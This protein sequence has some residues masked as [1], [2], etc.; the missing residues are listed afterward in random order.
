MGF[1]TP[2]M[3]IYIPAAGETNYD[4]SFAAGMINI[5][6]HDHSGGP[7][8]GVQLAASGLAD[9]SVTFEKLNADVVDTATGLGVSITEPNKLQTTGLLKS[10]YQI[11]TTNG[12]IAKNNTA[13]A[14]RTLTGT[15]D[16]I[17]ITNGDGTTGNP[18]FSLAPNFYG[19]NTFTPTIQ[20]S[21]ADITGLS[22][23]FQDGFYQ[24]IGKWIMVNLRINATAT[25]GTGNLF[26]ENLP[27]AAFT[28]SWLSS[29]ID[30]DFLSPS[31]QQ[32]I[33]PQ[34]TGSSIDIFITGGGATRLA[35][36]G[37]G[38]PFNINIQMTGIY[39]WTA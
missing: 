19:T 1:V 24:K 25:G 38:T 34:V 33:F 27:I 12:F 11:A 22:Y 36:A 26:L 9:G 18:V 35:A 14:A 4:A 5:D 28:P 39:Q 37:A 17:D 2:N 8:K 10:I 3:G 20:S 29:Y 31:D 13:A 32:A 15:T 7:N 16:Q 23:I 6:Q 30:Y 21:N